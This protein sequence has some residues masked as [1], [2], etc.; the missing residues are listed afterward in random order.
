M[1]HPPPPRAVITLQERP[2]HDQLRYKR[3]LVDLSTE[4]TSM[5]TDTSDPGAGEG[6]E[7]QAEVCLVC[8]AS[9]GDSLRE[10]PS[11]RTGTS[12]HNPDDISGITVA[13][14][15][16]TSGIFLPHPNHTKRERISK[17]SRE[18]PLANT[19][20]KFTASVPRVCAMTP[21]YD[22]AL[23]HQHRPFNGVKTALKGEL[24]PHHRMRPR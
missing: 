9:E 6:A 18:N 13:C 1:K 10:R 22:R 21:R 14:I 11:S 5:P 23:K 12:T 4:S 7:V 15:Y 24:R 19:H 2:F 8:Q 3:E 17:C 16:A 20:K